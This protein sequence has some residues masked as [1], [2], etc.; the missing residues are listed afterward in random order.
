MH[1]DLNDLYYYVQ[2]VDHGGFA[3]AGR[4]LGIAKS[5]LSRRIGLLEER[6]GVRL[7]QRSSRT[8]VVTELGQ[9][10]YARCRAMLVEAEAAQ[11]VIESIHAQPCGTVRLACPMGLLHAHVGAMLVQFAQQY[12]KV[13]VQLMGINRAVDLVSEGFDLALRI[14]PLPLQDS[15]LAMRTLGY[16]EQYLVASP[17]LLAQ[18]GQPQTLLDLATWP[19]LG[20]GAPA[21]GYV[22]RLDAPGLGPVQQRYSPAFISNDM[23]TLQAAAI[24]GIGV[25]QLPAM[26]ISE[27]LS[28]G[29][30]LRLLADWAVQREVIHIVFPSRRGLLPSVR[31][32]IDFLV[33]RFKPLC[34][35]ELR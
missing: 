6:L 15:E 17:A 35:S 2:V 21:E 5:K 18:H 3:Q 12:P 22:W 8:F 20:Y 19:S 25:A 13:N 34:E 32:L 16:T 23:K 10:Y 27:A 14:R 4:A 29:R 9:A 1:Q 7:I 26:L 24:A 31:T 11:T 33:E 28:D 30:L